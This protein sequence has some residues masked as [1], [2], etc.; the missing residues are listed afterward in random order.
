MHPSTLA[1][2]MFITGGTLFAQTT[3]VPSAA[4]TKSPGYW[5]SQFFYGTSSTSI[6]NEGHTQILYSAKD[7]GSTVLTFKNMQVRRPQN[8]G[9][10]NLALTGNMRLVLSSSKVAPTA[11]SSTFASNHGTATVVVNSQISLPARNRGA[12]WP[13]P[14]ETAIPFINSYIYIE[15]VGGSFVVEN[16]FSNNSAQR[17]WYVEGDRKDQGTRATNLSAC[18]A[19]SDG[20]RNNSIGYRRPE[21]GGSF[22]LRYGSMPSNVPSLNLSFMIIGIGGV[23]ASQWGMTL[24]INLSQLSLPSNNCSLAVTDD[25]RV[26]LAYTTSTAGKNRGSLTSPTI[27]IPNNPNLGGL[28]F[29]E[30]GV[31]LDTNATTKLPEIYMCWSSKWTIGTGT[32]RPLALVYRTGDNSQTTGFVRQFE[33]PTLRFN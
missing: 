8:L 4:K 17:S 6:K 2:A 29:Y 19:H 14:W 21:V 18:A 26:P 11:A 7:V 20:G 12:T 10:Q 1:V 31:A 9:N 30:H 25:I 24:P 5:S 16:L 3:V 22:Y 28:S 13:D 15:Q 32:G 33:G 27:P 23:G